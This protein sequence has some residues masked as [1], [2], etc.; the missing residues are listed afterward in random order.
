MKKLIVTIIVLV[1]MFGSPI[2]AREGY[3]TI[4]GGHGGP[5]DSS[6]I[7]FEFGRITENYFDR[8]NLIALGIPIILNNEGLPKDAVR[9]NDPD[10]SGWYRFESRYGYLTDEGAVRSMP[11]FGF[12]VKYGIETIKHSRL[13]ATVFGGVTFA[14]EVHLYTSALGPPDYYKDEGWNVYGLYGVGLSYFPINSKLVVT[15][16]CDSRRGV[17]GSVGWRW[18]F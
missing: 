5:T 16:D 11:E 8:D 6:N 10:W 14:D 18:E 7:T 3:F 4:G 17:T 15:V 9:T 1:G 13:F 12:F 2:V